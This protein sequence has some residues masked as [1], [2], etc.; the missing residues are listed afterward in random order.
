MS[1]RSPVD[2]ADCDAVLADLDGVLTKTATVHAAAWKELFD[3]YLAGRAAREGGGF[4][5]FD[6]ARDY[7][8]YVDG[9]P[10]YDGVHSFLA[11][12][13]ITLPRGDPADPPDRET[14]C[15]LGNRK[16]ALFLERLAADGVAA[17][18]DAVALVHA[19][20][21]R[22]VKLAVVT[23]SR[24]G[25]AVLA[26]AGLTALFA[27]RVDGRELARLGLPGKP[28]PDMFLEAARRLGAEPRRAAVLEDSVAG[29]AAARAGG[30]GLVVG[31]D[32]EGQGPQLAA[33]G[34]DVV[35]S[36]LEQLMTPLAP[37]DG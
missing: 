37:R 20:Q 24:N 26:A 15:G 33:H 17:Y 23:S 6:S 5:P 10:R 27:V 4:A 31:V 32:R 16:N 35:L 9:K 30:F 18:P 22:G 7:R 2:W 25:E 19:A 11:S 8:D 14:I 21:R 1:P 28:A 36:N 13:G 34:A 29:V 12:R 3:G